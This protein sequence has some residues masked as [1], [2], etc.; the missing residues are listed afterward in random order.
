MTWPTKYVAWF[1]R[2]AG[3]NIGMLGQR[4]SRK[5]SYHFF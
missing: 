3:K 4:T 2:S 5:F 1:E